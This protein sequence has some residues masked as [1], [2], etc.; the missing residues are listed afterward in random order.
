M[1]HFIGFDHLLRLLLGRE[2]ILTVY[3]PSG[4]ID[5]LEHK[6]AGYSWNLVQNYSNHFEIIV[7]EINPDSIKGASFICRQGFKRNDIPDTRPFNGLL[8]DE[9]AF[10]V[11]TVILDHLLPSLAFCFAE[12]FHLNINK[13]R[14]Q[15][16]GLA[17]GPWLKELKQWVWEKR[18]EQDIFKVKYELGGQTKSKSFPFGE[19]KRELVSISPGE[20]VTYVADAVYSRDNAQKIRQLA[21]GADYFFCEAAFMD[22]EREQARK[23]YHLTARQAGEIARKAGVKR[24][25]PFHFSPRYSDNLQQIEQEAQNAFMRR[26][27]DKS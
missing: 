24:F 22:K 9:A 18:N 1:D 2:K 25:I 13:V 5:K 7:H 11:S 20:K 21:D 10:G 19:L 4:I 17:P 12:K 3:G 8:L 23:T 6:L 16:L 26:L 14:L 15:E 27:S